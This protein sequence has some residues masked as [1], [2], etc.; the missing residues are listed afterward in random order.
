MPPFPPRGP[1]G[2]FPH[3]LGLIEALRLPA[4]RPTSLRFLRSAVPTPT[5]VEA[6]DGGISQVPVGP[7]CVH[8]LLYDPGGTDVPGLNQHDD[9]AFRLCNGVGSHDS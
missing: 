2:R 3:F 6:R 4:V 1:S 8:A 7:S 5:S 9:V